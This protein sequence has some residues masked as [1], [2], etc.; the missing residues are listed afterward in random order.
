MEQIPSQKAS[1]TGGTFNWTT[2]QQANI[3]AA[4]FYGY[5]IT[6]LPAGY[7]ASKYGGKN[8]MG[9]SVLIKSFLSILNPPFAY[10]GVPWLITLRVIE[11]MFEGITIPAFSHL[12]ARWS[13]EMERTLFYGL[14]LSGCSFGLIF[15]YSSAGLLCTLDFLGGWPLGFLMNGIFGVIWFFVWNYTSADSPECH[16]RIST[17]EREYILASSQINDQ[18]QSKIPWKEMLKSP[19][20][21]AFVILLISLHVV[22]YALLT[23]LPLYFLNVLNFDTDLDGYLCAFLWFCNMLGSIF[24]AYVTDRIRERKVISTTGNRFLFPM[25]KPYNLI[26]CFKLRILCDSNEIIEEIGHSSRTALFQI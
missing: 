18:V 19:P 14:S 3:L 8:I 25:V 23:G 15:C 1:L 16:P 12:T 6:Q 7:L 22:D 24:P 5:V 11:G 2:T 4:H 17:S 13:P 9:Y 10:L 26:Q 20:F 21:H